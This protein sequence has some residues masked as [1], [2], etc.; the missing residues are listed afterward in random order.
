MAEKRT[1]ADSLRRSIDRAE[2]RM[3]A[4]AEES[5]GEA[6]SSAITN[7]R[8]YIAAKLAVRKQKR[9]IRELY[10]QLLRETDPIAYYSLLSDIFSAK[11]Q[12]VKLYAEI[13]EWEVR[14]GCLVA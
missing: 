6:I 13:R 4:R 1:K 10:K 8:E 2:K 9:A 7:R 3:G 5:A 12:L 11:A 14:G